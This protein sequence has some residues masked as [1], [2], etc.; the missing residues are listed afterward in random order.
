MLTLIKCG[1]VSA[2]DVMELL[3]QQKQGMPEAVLLPSVE[4][5]ASEPVAYLKASKPL[6][7]QHVLRVAAGRGI[8]LAVTGD[9]E[10]WSFGSGMNLQLGTSNILQTDPRPVTGRL[11]RMIAENGG[12]VDIAVG[13]AFCLALARNGSVIMWGTMA[14]EGL[15]C[16]AAKGLPGMV[17]IA[18]GKRHAVFTDG[19]SIWHCSVGESPAQP[20]FD[21]PVRLKCQVRLPIPPHPSAAPALSLL[22]DLVTENRLDKKVGEGRWAVCRVL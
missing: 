14:P 3:G 22:C 21:R 20:G 13:G 10:L 1:A 12:A 2:G 7:K 11:A 15:V 19:E 6:Y 17:K 18:A 5:D 8:S 9:G 16:N 4:P